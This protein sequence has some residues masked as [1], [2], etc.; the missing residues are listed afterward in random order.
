MNEPKHLTM[1]DQWNVQF[2][3][4]K[5]Y[6][7]DST[8]RRIVELLTENMHVSEEIPIAHMISAVPELIEALELILELRSKELGEWLLT[9]NAKHLTLKEYAQAALAKARGEQS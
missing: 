7:R 9:P 2:Y 4:D 1:D 3:G 6:I 8:N 5:T